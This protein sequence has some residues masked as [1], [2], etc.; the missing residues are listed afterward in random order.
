MKKTYELNDNYIKSNRILSDFNLYGAN[1]NIKQD[2][3]KDDLKIYGRTSRNNGS[4][5]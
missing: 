2:E 1:L 5:K 3:V 4:K